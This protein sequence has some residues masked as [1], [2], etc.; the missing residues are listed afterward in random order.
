MFYKKE[1]VASS[2]I[3]P[4]CSN[5]FRDPRIIP[6]STSACHEC[7]QS[8]SDANMKLKCPACDEEH[9]PPSRGGVFCPNKAL[10]KIIAANASDVVRGP[11]VECL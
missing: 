4:L 5:I 2:L 10:I 1:D 11:S 8:R 7:I 6:C 9:Q 3:C